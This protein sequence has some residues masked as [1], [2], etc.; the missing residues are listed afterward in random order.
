MRSP[1]SSAR[2]DGGHGART[3]VSS[4]LASYRSYISRDSLL[5]E[6][7]I[8]GVAIPAEASGPG[9]VKQLILSSLL[10]VAPLTSDEA[11]DAEE[12]AKVDIDQ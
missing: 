2:P 5:S 4:R 12:C 10:A 6:L 9:R 11:R 3:P 8:I 1:L 7:N